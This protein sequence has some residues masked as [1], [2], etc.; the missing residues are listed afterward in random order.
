MKHRRD[1]QSKEWRTKV[2]GKSRVEFKTT[3]DSD[4]TTFTVNAAFLFFVRYM[5]GAKKKIKETRKRRHETQLWANG[6]EFA[7][8]CVD[9]CARK[10][11][12]LSF[13]FLFFG[14]MGFK[15]KQARSFQGH[16]QATRA[17]ARMCEEKKLK[18]IK[19]TTPTALLLNVS[20]FRARTIL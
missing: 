5:S 18:I 12:T 4:A 1:K 3:E 10:C 15:A 2:A 16:T 7:R 8:C 13:F 11:L 17:M 14:V 9:R 20:S 19:I 6:V